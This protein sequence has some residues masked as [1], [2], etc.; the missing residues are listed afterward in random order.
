VK[1]W[2]GQEIPVRRS[3]GGVLTFER[4]EDNVLR[5]DAE[6][7][8]PA[9]LLKQV[10]GYASKLEHFDPADA[11]AL[12]ADLAGR[13]S[14]FQSINSE[15]AVTWSWFGT[16]GFAPAAA[17]IAVIQWLY[18]RIGLDA[19]A[20]EPRIDQWMRVFHPNAPGSPRGPE[21]DARVDDQ[22]ALVY[23]EAK[24]KADI[25]TGRGK[26][27]EIPADQIDLRRDSLRT[28]PALAD[29]QRALAVLGVSE[30]TPNLD[31]WTGFNEG[32]QPVTIAWLNWDELAACPAHPL[33]DEFARY[34]AWK[35]EHARA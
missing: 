35:R 22:V 11:D 12:E 21:L 10:T 29:D 6:P 18:D 14:R 16:L 31:K 28:D 4:W 17:R 24:W 9:Q 2:N 30:I 7:W 20:V 8:P 13:I 15:D 23:V 27:L 32:Q 25:G 3:R 33:A 5:G 26:D 34:L 1:N 19:K